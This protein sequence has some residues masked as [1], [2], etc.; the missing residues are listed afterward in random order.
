MGGSSRAPP[1]ARHAAEPLPGSKRQRTGE[2]AAAPAGPVTS[3][4]RQP[5]PLTAAR[6]PAA[7][8][9]AGAGGAG[10]GGGGSA[11]Q[12][13]GAAPVGGLLP[14]GGQQQQQQQQQQQGGPDQLPGDVRA[15]LREVFGRVL[16][17]TIPAAEAYLWAEGVRSFRWGWGLCVPEMQR[18]W[19]SASRM[20]ETPSKGGLA[21]LLAVML[22]CC[23][24]IC[25]FAMH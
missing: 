18:I 20:Q 7:G 3:E 24:P 6:K 4:P 13:V 25:H 2:A 5:Q 12:G 10:R 19:C 8:K 14:A 15:L 9:Q 1:A 23:S 16:P 21:V 17:G 22:C 11:P